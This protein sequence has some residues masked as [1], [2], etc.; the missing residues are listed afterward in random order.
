MRRRSTESNRVYQEFDFL[1]D[2]D[3]KRLQLIGAISLAWNWLEGAID[4]ALGMAL[5]LHPSM[6]LEVSGRVNGMDAKL[7]IIRASVCLFD[8]TIPVETQN[9]VKQTL[10]HVGDHKKLRDGVIHVRLVHPDAEVAETPQRRTNVDEVLI[11]A[12]ALQGLY[13]RL[14]LLAKEANEVAIY[15]KDR[16]LIQ[17]TESDETRTQ[18]AASFRQSMALLLDLQKRRVALPPLPE[19]PA[20]PQATPSSEEG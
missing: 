8:G 1:T 20:T 10:T 11:S 19:F 15:F 17:H 5:E 2:V 12:A 7:G 9:L 6:W 4:A 18:A 3:A 13:D 14:N 16:W